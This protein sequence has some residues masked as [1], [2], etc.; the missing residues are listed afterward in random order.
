MYPRPKDMCI[1]NSEKCYQIALQEVAQI[2]TPT[3]QW[4]K[5]VC[6][7]KISLIFS[8]NILT[9]ADPGVVFLQHWY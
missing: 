5:S 9:N 7:L 6:F 2:Y 4:H 8:G 3:S 1:L